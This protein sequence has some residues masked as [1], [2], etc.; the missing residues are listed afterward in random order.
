MFAAGK[1]K[2]QKLFRKMGGKGHTK[3]SKVIKDMPT[4]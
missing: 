4:T 1:H 2:E 3:I